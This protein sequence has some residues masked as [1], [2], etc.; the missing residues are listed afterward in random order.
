MSVG[1]LG[2]DWLDAN[3]ERSYPLTQDSTKRDISGVFTLPTNFLVDLGLSVSSAFNVQPTKF[4][5]YKLI[6][7]SASLLV[8]VGYSA[9]SGPKPVAIARI[10]RGASA[11][12]ATYPLRGVGD[13]HDSTGF[14]VVGELASLDSLPSGYFE[15][16]LDGGRLETEVV[17]PQLRG[18]PRLVVTNSGASVPLSSDIELQAGRNC[19]LVV[20]TTTPIPSIR[21]DFID[22]EG[23]LDNC[24][25]G[26]NITDSPPI[27]FI[28]DIPGTADGKFYLEGDECIELEPIVNGLRLD[29]KC[30]APCCGQGEKQELINLAQ[31]LE[32]K[33]R[34]LE[35]FV[36]SLNSSVLQMENTVLGTTIFDRG[37]QPCS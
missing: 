4:F 23:T 1:L 36:A 12:F 16:S 32:S 20:D 2:H 27:R 34:T 14:V 26:E 30:S 7:D 22:G 15:F 13:F 11:D 33:I 37:G 18:I 3:S 29:N 31:T 25:C 8:T 5:L 24:D 6:V 19:R 21:I 9:T 28:N 17:R 35:N 10:L